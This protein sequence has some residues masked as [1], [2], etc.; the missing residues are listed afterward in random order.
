VFATAPFW[1]AAAGV[2]LIGMLNVGVSFS[3]AILVAMRAVDISPRNRWAVYRSLRRRLLERPGEFIW[4]PRDPESSAG[5]DPKVETVVDG[6][7]PRSR[8]RVASAPRKDER[9]EG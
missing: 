2:A 8:P 6:Q 9:R 3:L 5:L 1:M 4:P 7:P